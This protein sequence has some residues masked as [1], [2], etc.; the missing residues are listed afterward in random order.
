L[1]THTNIPSD[2]AVQSRKDQVT[3]RELLRCA[4]LDDKLANALRVR[5]CL[6]PLDGIL[7]LFACR[8]LRRTDSVQNKVWVKL[9]QQDEALA[10]GARGAEHTCSL[11][12][13]SS[14]FGEAIDVP[15]FFLGKFLLFE[16][17]LT[18]SIL[19]GRD[20]RVE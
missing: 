10:N 4:F 18:A 7:V 20:M 8:A 6:L 1:S 5:Q 19:A 12:E 13:R 15:H 14:K 16:V 3:V 2:I 11:C 17:K 9:Q